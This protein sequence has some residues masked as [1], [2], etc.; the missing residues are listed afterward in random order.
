VAITQW[1][2]VELELTQLFSILVNA[3]P[4]GVVSAVFSSVLNFNTKL[5]MVEAAAFVTLRDTPLFKECEEIQ[6]RL[7]K[8][9][10]KRNQIAHFML[11]QKALMLSASDPLPTMEAMNREVDWYLQPSAF[12]G[13]RL[14]HPEGAPKLTTNDLRIALARL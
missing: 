5:K 8:K 4:S 14:K 9:A 6:T 11:H 13:A 7:E 12:D 10:R 1:Q 2:Y 3:K